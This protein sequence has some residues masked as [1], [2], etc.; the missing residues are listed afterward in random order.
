MNSFQFHWMDSKYN[1]RCVLCRIWDLSF[2]SIEW[3]PSNISEYVAFDD[4]IS[5][6][7]IEW[8]PRVAYIVNPG[9][10]SKAIFQFHWMD[11]RNTQSFTVTVLQLITFNSIEWIRGRMPWSLSQV[12]TGYLSIPLNG[13]TA[14]LVL[15]AALVHPLSIP[16]NGF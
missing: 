4:E 7:S 10:A 6:N 11:S 3:I 13:F 9:R 8:I 15:L 12:D 16:L 2:N 1:V 14:R 5:F